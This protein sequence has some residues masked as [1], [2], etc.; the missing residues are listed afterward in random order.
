L[1]L[2]KL[3]KR[4]GK[5]YLE[6]SDALTKMGAKSPNFIIL[7]SQKLEESEKQRVNEQERLLTNAPP[8]PPP[9][10]L[11]PGGR[12]WTKGGSKPVGLLGAA[13]YGSE[14]ELLG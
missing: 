1:C 6:A 12:S 4:R 8:P 5:I 3:G 14:D 7:L 9:Q 11:S 13:Q 2:S 10:V